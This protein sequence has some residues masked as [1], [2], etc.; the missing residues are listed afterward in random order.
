MS[1]LA[2]LVAD[3]G[4][5]LGA[6]LLLDGLAALATD[7]GEVLGAVLLLDRL[8]ALVA[9]LRVELG[10][11]LIP[12]GLAA[13]SSGLLYRHAFFSRFFRPTFALSHDALL[14]RLDRPLRDFQARCR[15]PTKTPLS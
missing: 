7:L 6:A 4:V 14:C 2:A 3:L 12:D 13:Q 9:D 1:S 11:A 5:E 15:F 10:T 8:A